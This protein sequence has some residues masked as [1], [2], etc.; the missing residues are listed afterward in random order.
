[1]AE[2]KWRSPDRTANII[3]PGADS[4]ARA[5]GFNSIVMFTAGLSGAIA[6]PAGGA[7]NDSLKKPGGPTGHQA[8]GNDPADRA[9]PAPAIDS[10]FRPSGRPTLAMSDRAPWRPRDRSVPPLRSPFLIFASAA[11]QRAGEFR[12]ALQRPRRSPLMA[13]SY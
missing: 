4:S 3:R 13:L 10:A 5:A 6:E 7:R 1:V 12:I 9:V 8:K 11:V 2:V